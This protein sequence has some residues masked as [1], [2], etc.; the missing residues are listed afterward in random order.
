MKVVHFAYG[1]RQKWA[2]ENRINSVALANLQPF[3]GGTSHIR[4]PAKVL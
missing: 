2:G 4:L 1:F 3:C